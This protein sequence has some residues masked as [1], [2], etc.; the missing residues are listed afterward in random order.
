MSLLGFI[1]QG[2]QTAGDIYMQQRQRIHEKN[3]A[4]YAYSKELE[5]WNRANE[6]NLPSAQ[7]QRLID[8]GLNPALMYKG[9]QPTNVAVGQMPKYNAPRQEYRMPQVNA[10]NTLSQYQDIKIKRAQEDNIK[11]Q[12]QLTKLRGELA[13]LGVKRESWLHGNIQQYDNKGN[14]INVT[15]TTPFKE[16]YLQTTNKY[17][18]QIQQL[19]LRNQLQ[20]L[21]LDYYLGNKFLRP[22]IGVGR[23]F[24]KK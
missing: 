1:G 24:I 23:L 12:T 17:Q 14:V 21:D 10:L 2:I 5:Q 13:T 7:R 16:R 8:A 6:Y 19:E 20:N 4:D 15:K 22:L 18:K 3:M 9:G 11:E